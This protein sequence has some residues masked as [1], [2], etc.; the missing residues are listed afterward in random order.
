MILFGHS[1]AFAPAETITMIGTL[2]F[3]AW[4]IVV[5]IGLAQRGKE[6][7]PAAPT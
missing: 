4:A 5:G 2:G 7:A 3:L 1:G 6:L